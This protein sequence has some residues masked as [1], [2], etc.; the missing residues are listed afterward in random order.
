MMDD[1]IE[2]DEK[3]KHIDHFTNQLCNSGYSWQ[4]SKEIIVSSLKGIKRKSEKRKESGEKRYRTAEESLE[5]RLEKK[6]TENTEWYKTVKEKEENDRDVKEKKTSGFRM[7]RRKSNWIKK[8]KETEKEMETGMIKGVLFLPYTANSELAKRVREKLE[9]YEQFS[10]LKIR[11]VE[12]TG[13]RIVD[14][15]HKSNPWAN[16]KCERKDCKICEGPE[17]KMWGRC[18]YRNVVYETQCMICLN[19]E[20]KKETKE[21]IEVEENVDK[22]RKRVRELENK[23]VREKVKGRIVKYIGETAR[24]CYERQ[25]EHFSDYKNMY[26]RSHILKHFLDAH[27]KIGIEEF[28]RHVRVRVIGRYKSS[29]E[30]QI[31]ESIWL[32]NNL[33]SGVTILNSRNEYNRCKIPRLGLELKSYDALEEFKEKELENQRK[34]ELHRLKE[35]LRYGKELPRNKK[36]KLS[37]ERVDKVKTGI[38][39][40]EMNKMLMK[41]REETLKR[42]IRMK[43]IRGTLSLLDKKKLE[44]KVEIWRELTTDLNEAAKWRVLSEVQIKIPERKVKSIDGGELKPA[45]NPGFE[46]LVDTEVVETSDVFSA[47]IITKTSPRN[48]D[49]EGMPRDRVS[50]LPESMKGELETSAEEGRDID[51][52]DE[53]LKEEITEDVTKV[54]LNKILVK[55]DKKPEG[56]TMDN[57]TQV[58]SNENVVIHDKKSKSITDKNKLSKN[59]TNEITVEKSLVC[60][61]LPIGNSETLATVTENLGRISEAF[62]AKTIKSDKNIINTDGSISDLVDCSDIIVD[63]SINETDR[64]VEL[65]DQ[66]SNVDVNQCSSAN[67]FNLKQPDVNELSPSLLCSSVAFNQLSSA[68]ESSCNQPEVNQ[69]SSFN[70]LSQ[71]LSQVVGKS[72]SVSDLHEIEMHVDEQTEKVDYKYLGARPKISQEL[73]LKRNTSAKPLTGMR[74]TSTDKIA[75][76]GSYSEISSKG[77]VKKISGWFDEKVKYSDEQNEKLIHENIQKDEN[78]Y[79]KVELDLPH[80]SLNSNIKKQHERHLHVKKLNQSKADELADHCE[81]NMDIDTNITPKNVPKTPESKIST[82]SGLL[83]SMGGRKMLKATDLKKGGGALAKTPIKNPRKN[84]AKV[85]SK[86]KPQTP[87]FK[88]ILERMKNRKR[89]KAQMQNVIS[90]KGMKIGQNSENRTTDSDAEMQLLVDEKHK[91][92]PQIKPPTPKIGVGRGRKIRGRKLE[93]VDDKRQQKID[94]LWKVK[95]KVREKEAL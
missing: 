77:Y 13:E 88:R 84:V 72:F 53:G 11:V 26:L 93:C 18:K 83:D 36:Q 91:E 33:N 46:R 79:M 82:D 32:N 70:E 73:S 43:R 37:G 94:D 20:E 9:L 87:E 29:F 41:S 28:E 5:K 66:C 78:N 3:I 51:H 57:V 47:E 81:V 31:G 76:S 14:A 21:R 56:I 16:N 1:N 48:D 15:L 45:G 50:L 23:E 52:F 62:P 85:M 12:K 55:H 49:S 95:P 63:F 25:R 39:N 19:S 64:N 65:V 4:Q 44:N 69:I 6:L 86:P 30:R 22:G 80:K 40:I 59:V 17:E 38:G 42:V 60:E 92:S 90:E 61:A 2:I 89:E 67:E 7:K 27:Q 35:K 71:S 8:L 24:S 54:K 68:N 58:K 34:Q 75:T 74:T 10:N